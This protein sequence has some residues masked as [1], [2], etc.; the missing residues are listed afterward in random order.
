MMRPDANSNCE[1][2]A[3]ADQSRLD[4]GSGVTWS[5]S[6]LLAPAESEICGSASDQA[7]GSAS[8]VA[9]RRDF[10]AASVGLVCT[11]ESIASLSGSATAGEAVV[12]ARSEATR[13]R[14]RISSSLPPQSF[15][16]IELG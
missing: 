12:K 11:A 14:M 5:M 2:L 15:D 16:R 10:C 13:M 4:G 7:C 1:P 9:L 8:R 3:V 6:L